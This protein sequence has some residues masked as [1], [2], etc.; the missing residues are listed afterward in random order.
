MRQARSLTGCALASVAAALTLFPPAAAAGELIA[1]D[2]AGDLWLYD[3]ETQAR[4]LLGELPAEMTGLAFAPDQSLVGLAH[5]GRLWAIDLADEVGASLL[6]SGAADTGERYQYRDL[7]FGSAGQLLTVRRDFELGRS[8]L[9]RRSLT[10]GDEEVL[11]PITLETAGGDDL[12]IYALETVGGGDLFA[13][14]HRS[15]YV[16]DPATGVAQDLGISF[17]EVVASDLAVDL[18]NL[19]GWVLSDWTAGEPGLQL[20][21]VDGATG[22]LAAG[23]PSY[24]FPFAFGPRSIAFRP[25]QGTPCPRDARTLCFQDGRFQVRVDWRDFG[26]AE[27]AGAAVV[28]RS[29]DSGQ[30]WF[31]DEPNRELLVKVLDGCANNGRYWVFLAGTTNVEVALTVT[32]LVT[33]A[34]R[35]YAS[36]LGETVPTRLDTDAFICDDAAGEVP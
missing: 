26:G 5:D 7:T 34:E 3:A 24:R 31:F 11:G 18:E 8:E 30:F 28:D 12:D 2:S 17:P 4:S 29:D 33:G 27:A 13:M 20:V 23:T 19:R 36:A 21:A 22:G 1:A 9:L 14:D 25:R 16:L 15:V 6:S 32:D 10:T 35:V